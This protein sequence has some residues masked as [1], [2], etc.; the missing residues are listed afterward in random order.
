MTGFRPKDG[1]V[2]PRFAGVPTFM[3]LPQVT[4]PHQLDIA[5]VG[6]PFDG[7]T[8][9][10]SG[11]RF[12]PREIRVQSAL[13][14]PYNPVLRMN[15]FEKMRVAD[16]GDIDV[17]PFSIEDTFQRI[18]QGIQV[19][20]AAGA[21]PFSIGGDHSISL[22]ILRALAQVHGCGQLG[23]IHFDSH[24]DTYDTYFGRKL[25]HGTPFRR[26]VEENLLD[27]HKVIQ[28]GIRGHL[29]DETDFDFNKEC[30]ITMVPIEEVF[31][32]G[33]P[34]VIKKIQELNGEKFYLS[35]DIDVVD[36]AFA[37][38]TGTPQIGGVTSYQ[39]LQLIRTLKEIDFVGCD[40]VEVS[41]PYDSAN[42]T[43]LLAA[44]LIFEILCVL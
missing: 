16:F 13:I 7:G 30:G 29:Y 25:T 40:L 20:V 1:L 35:F 2:S 28:I 32:R 24:V 15:P 10:R 27:P 39:A 38:G 3:R 23:M 36:P 31:E 4:D 11:T 5:L 19:I 22:P 12:G 26:A 42:I 9:Y 41:P 37:P 33:I 6:V 21:R 17:N 18:Q 8:S 34:F 44:N 43:S 14:R